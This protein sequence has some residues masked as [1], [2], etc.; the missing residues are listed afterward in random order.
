MTFPTTRETSVNVFPSPEKFCIHTYKIV[1]IEWSREIVLLEIIMILQENLFD[2][3]VELDDTVSRWI[4]SVPDLYRHSRSHYWCLQLLTHVLDDFFEFRILWIDEI[5]PSQFSY[6]FKKELF[7]RQLLASL[8][9]WRA[10]PLTSRALYV[11]VFQ[12]NREWVVQFLSDTSISEQFESI[13]VASLQQISFLLLWC[14]DH[15][16]ME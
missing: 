13:H 2:L 16:C 3:L 7:I 1:S 5:D 12:W 14:D 15:R 11:N 6:V 10:F 4:F 9:D 8:S